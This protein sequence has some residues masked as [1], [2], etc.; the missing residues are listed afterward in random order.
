MVSHAGDP[1][2]GVP[3]RATMPL[4][5]G[6]PAAASAKIAGS[7]SASF[8]DHSGRRLVTGE[9]LGYRRSSAII[10]AW[11]VAVTDDRVPLA[12]ALPKNPLLQGAGAFFILPLPSARCPPHP[13]P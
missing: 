12:T 11:W 6:M 7:I 5:G 2:R 8:S 3:A 1:I 10:T 13:T 4:H 9:C